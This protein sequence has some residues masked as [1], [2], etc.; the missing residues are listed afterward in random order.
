M[1]IENI[2][3]MLKYKEHHNIKL[4]ETAK[5]FGIG[6]NKFRKLLKQFN[7][8]LPKKVVKRSAETIEKIKKTNLISK[9]SPV[10]RYNWDVE[11]R[12]FIETNKNNTTVGINKFCKS[13]GYASKYLRKY[14]KENNL[15]Q[16]IGIAIRTD[17]W[18]SK[19]SN[20]NKGKIN[21]PKGSNGKLKGKRLKKS[22]RDN[23]RAGLVKAHYNMSLE[24]WEKLQG[25]RELYYRE[26]W[27]ITHQQPLELLE[28]YD[29]RGNAGQKD[30]YQIDHIY[31]I[32]MGFMNGISAD[33]IG[34]ISNL[35]M[36]YWLDN[37]KK[38]NNI[39]I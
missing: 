24:E 18:K 12:L 39:N 37:R 19:I 34:N 7:V 38:G 20:S 26:V 30:A 8:K 17:D 23:I 36:L 21:N 5:H 31:P 22:H 9:N 1:S 28:N 4:E 10:L 11:Y 3:E 2:L 15:Y 27:R 29:K 33:I 25:D 32:S 16:P 13:R 35:Q 14:I 6:I